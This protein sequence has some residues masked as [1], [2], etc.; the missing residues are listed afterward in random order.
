MATNVYMKEIAEEY[1]LSH[2]AE[3]VRQRETSGLFIRE[4]CEREGI[5]ENRYYYW[6]K[7]LR[8]A[9]CEDLAKTNGNSTSLVPA[10]FAE[11]KLPAQPTSQPAM[12]ILKNQICIEAAG[13]RVTAD[14]EYP[15]D[16]LSALLSVVNRSCC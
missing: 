1:R 11:V 15:I 13:I 9:A 14:G 2:W 8:E 6:Q 3:I 12:T 10:V 5:H 16:K 4:F 7:K